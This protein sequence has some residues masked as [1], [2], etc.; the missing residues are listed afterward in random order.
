MLLAMRKAAVLTLF[1]LAILWHVSF[2][3]TLTKLALAQAR[4]FEA[5]TPFGGFESK[6]EVFTSG[7]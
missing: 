5:A 3:A 4:G 7:S 2:L 1:A 6:D